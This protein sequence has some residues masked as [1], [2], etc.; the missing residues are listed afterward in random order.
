MG[1]NSPLPAAALQLG[2]VGSLDDGAMSVA[3]E[4]GV[5]AEGIATDGHGEEEGTLSMDIR[6]HD[7]EHWERCRAFG[8]NLLKMY[9]CFRFSC[10]R[11]IGTLSVSIYG[12]LDTVFGDSGL[13]C[14]QPFSLSCLHEESGAAASGCAVVS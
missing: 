14:H 11:S 3:E 2:G 8:E 12:A 13:I 7:C 5:G 9:A 1:N 10:L 4:A 6:Q